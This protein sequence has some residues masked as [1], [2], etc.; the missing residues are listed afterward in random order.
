VRDRPC[1]TPFSP[2]SLPRR[3]FAILVLV[4]AGSLSLCTGLPRG[5]EGYCPAVGELDQQPAPLTPGERSQVRGLRQVQVIVRHGERSLYAPM[6][7][8]HGWA[9][10]LNCSLDIS[11]ALQSVEGPVPVWRGTNGTCQV[12]QFL[13][14]G[15]DRIRRLGRMVRDTYVGEGKP[16]GPLRLDDTEK[17]SVRSTSIE[18]TIVTAFYLTE[19]MKRAG[20]QVPIRTRP[21]YT[22]PWKLKGCPRATAEFQ[23]RW[24]E[25]RRELKSMPDYEAFLQR[26]S[27]AGNFNFTPGLSTN[28]GFNYDCLLVDLCERQGAPA[29]VTPAL[30]D[31]ALDW[32][33][34]YMNRVYAS[35]PPIRAFT[36][37]MAR[38]MQEMAKSQVKLG[39]WATHDTALLSLWNGLGV[40]DGVYPAYGDL[41]TLEVYEL[42]GGKMAFRLLRRGKPVSVPGCSTLCP[43]SHLFDI[44]ADLHRM[45]HQRLCEWPAPRVPLNTATN[46]TSGDSQVAPHVVGDS[47]SSSSSRPS[48]NGG[49]Q[50]VTVT[51]N[52][53]PPI[54]ATGVIY[55]IRH[56]EKIA[57]GNHLNATGLGRAQHV[58]RIWGGGARSRYT[59]PKAIFAN[60]R[61]QEFNSIELAT[62][63]AEKLG[64]KVNSSFH[65]PKWGEDNYPAAH[66]ILRALNKT[67]G[68]VMAVWESWNIVPL[69]RDLGCNRSWEAQYDGGFWGK[70]AHH[71]RCFDNF[72]LLRLKDGKCQDISL[73]REGF[74]AC[75]T[76]AE[77]CTDKPHV[78]VP[79]TVSDS[80]PTVFLLMSGIAGVALVGA[81]ATKL[82]R[83]QRFN[84]GESMDSPLLGGNKWAARAFQT[85]SP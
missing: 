22:D 77:P 6:P 26:W 62:P 59:P 8:F 58:A 16:L 37:R 33:L 83:R 31:A 23:A 63:L 13:P 18:R 19:G 80:K 53:G 73:E 38:E 45:G 50:A 79:S 32:A 12:G 7:C 54:D 75:K 30:R 66:A 67:G 17:V 74:K 48:S 60:F 28:T 9:P 46:G 76:W 78:P 81:V 36:H 44:T 34:E 70:Y 15:V 71:D 5:F 39:V 61:D 47:S 41:T 51:G 85:P 65:R 72:L 24:H 52:T 84:S 21:V 40:W 57:A 20:E 82:F 55:V 14:H 35:S 29:S 3:S 43:L 27:S 11:V 42:H 1:G 25:V 10:K 64:L 49:V 69:A 4:G 68:P 2:M 56:G